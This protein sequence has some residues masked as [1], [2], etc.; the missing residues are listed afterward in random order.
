MYGQSTITK[1]LLM[2]KKKCLCDMLFCLLAYVWICLH[3]VYELAILFAC[4]LSQ[5]MWVLMYAYA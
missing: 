2:T 4:F 5:Y 3:D 1:S